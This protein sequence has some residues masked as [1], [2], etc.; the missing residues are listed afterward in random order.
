MG[1][2][3]TQIQRVDSGNKEVTTWALPEGA[4]ARL[5]RGCVRD[6]AL[7]PDRK[8]LAVATFMG[9]WVYELPTMVPIHLWETD[10]GMSCRLNFSPNGKWLAIGNFDQTLKV[11]D[12]DQGKS[13]TRIES[14]KIRF[15]SRLS[16]VVFSND[17]QYIATSEPLIGI[18]HLWHAETGEQIAEFQAAP[19]IT[20][21]WQGGVPRPLC[22]SDDGQFLACPSPADI[23]GTADFIAVWHVETGEQMASLRGHTARV[24]ALDFSPCGQYLAAGDVSG[25]TLREWDVTAGTQVRVFSYPEKYRRITPT[26]SRSGSLLAAGVL[27]STITVWNVENDEK[28]NTFDSREDLHVLRFLA[29]KLPARCRL[30]PAL[31]FA[32]E[33]E[34]KVWDTENPRAV[35]S[36]SREVHYPHFVAFLPDGRTLVSVD[37]AGTTYWDVAERRRQR[38]IAR[39]NTEIRSVYI[40][41]TGSV[42]A[43][44][45]IENTLHVWDVDTDETITTFAGHQEFVRTVA[46]APTGARFASADTEGGLYVWD[47]HG[48]QTALVG[49]TRLIR[50]LA[51]DRD[52]KQLVSGSRDG[53]ARIWDVTSGKEIA[54]LPLAPFDLTF[55]SE[56]YIGDA[57][58]KQRKLRLQRERHI[59]GDTAYRP[60]TLEAV[61]FSPCGRLI[62]GGMD[63]E[64]RLWDATTYE[65]LMAILPPQECRRPFA[66]TFSPC[67]RYFASGSWWYDGKKAP[68]ALWEVATG[69]IIATLPGHTTD[70]QALAFSPDGTLLASASYDGTILL[71]DLKPYK[72]NANLAEVGYFAHKK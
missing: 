18:V 55:A 42:L 3:T 10:R 29:E 21:R 38:S 2:Q 62:V 45:S 11:W 61:A 56:N 23:E 66:L 19:D 65:L 22:F 25:G 44:G 14:S 43:L 1:N 24:Y 63:N 68:I 8:T 41:P 28:L 33:R 54:T 15:R 51:F 32:S 52:G 5:G 4:I 71:W 27:Q 7:S 13:I 36:I 58:Q 50:S 47:T 30:K 9:V 64:I 72:T 31:I 16:R 48:K 60:V 12:V 34:I 49:H 17:S 20:V 35:A 59:R 70:V 57:A 26:Y 67:G 69:E 46:F 6:L 53:T 39:P 40:S 37:S